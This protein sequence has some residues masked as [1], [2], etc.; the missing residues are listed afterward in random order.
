VP[1]RRLHGAVQRRGQRV[2]LQLRHQR[3]GAHSRLLER[4]AALFPRCIF[5][6]LCPRYRLARPRDHHPR[7]PELV[8]CSDGICAERP[9]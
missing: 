6:T 3:A 5:V 4:Y 7:Q 8:R 9:N 1:G 2:C